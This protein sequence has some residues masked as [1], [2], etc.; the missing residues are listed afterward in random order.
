MPVDALLLVLGAALGHAVWNVMIAGRKDMHAATTAALII[1]LVLFSPAIV[2]TWEFTAEAIPWLIASA[3]LELGYFIVLI[4]AYERFD[5]SL[6]YPVARGLA[7][8]LV[9]LV[10]TGFLG[11]V[12]KPLDIVG[13]LI[14]S[15]GILLVRRPGAA[16][17]KG[18][19]LGIVISFCIMGFTLID[20]EGIQ[21]AGTIPFF[22]MAVLPVAIAGLA[23]RRGA[24][25]KAMDL[26]TAAIGI[27]MFGG[28]TL[29]LYGLKI[30]SP[31]AAQATRESSIVMT[32]IL[33]A[34]VLKEPVSRRRFTGVAIVL[35]GVILIA[36]S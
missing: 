18:I 20:R 2:L 5:L 26:R 23:L 30:A 11:V 32:T 19:A 17:F 35:C 8:V 1:G 25:L 14:V 16:E 13:V 15:A 22:S 36:V 12:A 34:V 28:Y 3:A 24:V 31:H 6:V 10:G 29:Y 4:Y 7:P 9:L 33:A 27:A 21:H